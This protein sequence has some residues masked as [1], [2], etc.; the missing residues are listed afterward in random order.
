MGIAEGALCVL[1]GIVI[2][3]IWRRDKKGTAGDPVPVCGC[4]HHYSM[5]DLE[6]GRCYGTVRGKP[7]K[8]NDFNRP[9]VW[10]QVPCTC[11]RYTGPEPLPAYYAP[12]VSS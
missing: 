11:R 1:I 7:L 4:E 8:Y 12:G 3:R 2:G 10:E 6:A 9:V 5:H